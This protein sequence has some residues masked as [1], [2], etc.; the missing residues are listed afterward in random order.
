MG[1]TPS[2]TDMM[3][4]NKYAGKM[5]NSSISSAAHA[6]AHEPHPIHPFAFPSSGTSASNSNPI[7]LIL[8]PG[9]LYNI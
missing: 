2:T 5:S 1:T 7:R 8:L 9:F 4:T 3:A 6:L